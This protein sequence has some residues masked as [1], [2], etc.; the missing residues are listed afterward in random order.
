MK[1]KL[2]ISSLSSCSGCI[3]TLLT[4]DIFPQFFERI[5]I[6]HFPFISDKL[7]I[8]DCEIALIEGSVTEQPQIKYLKEIRT[9]AKRLYALGT[10][11]AFGGI[12]SLSTKKYSWP[13][14]DFIEIDG[15]IP[16]CPPPPIL[17]GNSMIRLI[18]NKKIIL[19][20]KNMCSTCP[21]RYSLKI[22]EV[23]E[24]E[25]LMPKNNDID[26]PEGKLICFLNKGILCMGPITRNGCD[27][28]CINQGIPCEGCMGPVSK[29]FTS[30]V[31]NFLSLFNIAEELKSYEGIFF[32][33][34]KPRVK[35]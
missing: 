5:E 22:S 2:I 8:N 30:N 21:L 25:S 19:E 3:S 24:I 20:E 29:D 12:V 23:S 17:L 10:C 31:V 7:K 1:L 6:E 35:R 33:F 9:H 18:E 27:N 11:A 4:L 26:F 15:I 16:G 13:I 14:S 28:M 34:S 32:R